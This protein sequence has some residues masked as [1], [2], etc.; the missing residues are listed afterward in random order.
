M[1]QM[2]DVVDMPYRLWG[3]DED[4]TTGLKC[5][6]T[7]QCRHCH[8]SME[9]WAGKPLNF[10]INDGTGE[11]NSYALDVT[12]WCPECGYLDLFGVPISKEHYEFIQKRLKFLPQKHMASREVLEARE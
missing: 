9:F 5:L 7:P 8:V 2:A 11:R 4:V 3:G 6:F 12:M 10:E 1:V